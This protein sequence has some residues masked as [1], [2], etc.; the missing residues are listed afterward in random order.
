MRLVRLDAP[1]VKYLLCLGL[2]TVP[3]GL[4]GYLA[5]D[6]I[7]GLFHSPLTA[8][9]G[10]LVTAGALFSTRWSSRDNSPAQEEWEPTPI[11]PARVLVIGMAQALAILPGISR[12]GL[13]I[14]ASL[15]IGLARAEAARFSFLLSIP[16]IAG[17]LV[18]QLAEG[19]T[20]VSGQIFGLAVAAAAAFLVG[21]LALRLTA[22]AVVQAHFWK[23][24]IYCLVMGLITVLIMG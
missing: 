21:W 18:L 5:R 20:V 3:A 17:A 2:G 15:W 16:A 14:T 9:F 13:T 19:A 24:G 8:G 6:I 23:F 11:H 10:L 12:S 4:V 22:L 1:A 7:M